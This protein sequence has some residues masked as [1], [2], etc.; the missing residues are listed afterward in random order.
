MHV[1]PMVINSLHYE[2]G[3]LAKESSLL[4]ILSDGRFEL[5]IG[6]GDWPSSYTAWGMRFPERAVRIARLAETIEALRA[7][8]RGEAVTFA[9][10]FH[11]LTDAACTPAPIVAPRVVIGVGP[12]KTL[13]GSAVAYADELNIYGEVALL[14]RVREL[15]AASGREVHVSMF[16]GWEWEK[17]PADPLAELS[18]W[19]DLGVDR[20]FVSLGANDMPRRLEQI[21]GLI[22]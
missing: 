20:A 1:T 8:W 14:D 9:G 6:A 13:A 21:A 11:Q 19:R 22:S 4:S 3:V 18:R 7:L 16:F 2:L 10:Q 5:A 15:I 17:W 12:S